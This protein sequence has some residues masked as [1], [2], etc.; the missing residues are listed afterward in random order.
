MEA[1]IIILIMLFALEVGGIIGF[2]KK[3]K[4]G[5]SQ[6]NFIIAL[7]SLILVGIAIGFQLNVLL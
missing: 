3:Q 1:Q 7:I 6:K 2:V 4:S 5:L